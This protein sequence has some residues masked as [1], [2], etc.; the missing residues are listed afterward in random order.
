MTVKKILIVPLFALGLFIDVIMGG[1]LVK[2]ASGFL[3]ANWWESVP[4]LDFG[5]AILVGILLM[6]FSSITNLHGPEYTWSAFFFRIVLGLGVVP[7]VVPWAV[8]ELNNSLFIAMPDITYG[9]T[10]V[11]A[12]IGFGIAAVSALLN[13]MVQMLTALILE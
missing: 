9:T 4:N 3:H 7:F 5:N 2:S 13:I 12:L 11:L 10:F 8:G 1:W 6:S